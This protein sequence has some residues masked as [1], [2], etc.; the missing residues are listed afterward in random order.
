ME[1]DIGVFPNRYGHKIKVT[2]HRKKKDSYVSK[3]YQ[4]V[5]QNMEIQIQV[6][7]QRVLTR[8]GKTVIKICKQTETKKCRKQERKFPSTIDVLGA[9]GQY[10]HIEM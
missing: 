5:A 10:S 4:H 1:I 9:S 8:Y 3:K 6:L 7:L 2:K